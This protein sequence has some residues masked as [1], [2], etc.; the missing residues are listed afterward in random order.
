MCQW[1]QIQLKLATGGIPK[2]WEQRESKGVNLVTRQ[3]DRSS[4]KV[5]SNVQVFQFNGYI[6]IV[7]IDRRGR[8]KGA[9]LIKTKT[10]PRRAGGHNRRGWWSTTDFVPPPHIDTS[11]YFINT[12]VKIMVK[13]FSILLA[14]LLASVTLSH[15]IETDVQTELIEICKTGC[16]REELLQGLIIYIHTNQHQSLLALLSSVGR[17]WHCNCNLIW[18]VNSQSC[19]G[20]VF[21]SLRGDSLLWTHPLVPFGPSF[22]V[23]ARLTHLFPSSLDSQEN[24]F[25]SRAG[26]VTMTFCVS[27]GNAHPPPQSSAYTLSREQFL[28]NAHSG[29]L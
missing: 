15:H 19:R 14:L 20:P 25:C 24:V 18:L 11:F 2:D 8:I 10:L 29:L 1:K 22:F 21:E 9:N 5:L 27:T 26:E 16:G 23:L 4:R 12:P 13:S 3:R 7:Y 6:H 17:A 28:A